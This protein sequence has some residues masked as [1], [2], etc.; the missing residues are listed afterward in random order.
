[1]KIICGISGGLGNQM[2]QYAYGRALSKRCGGELLL[3]L[4]WFDESYTTVTNRPLG[5]DLFNFDYKVASEEDILNIKGRGKRKKG[6]KKLLSFD[7]SNFIKENHYHFDESLLNVKKDSYF[8]GYFQSEKYFSDFE[9][10][11]KSDFAFKDE[12]ND[13]YKKL[14]Q[15][16]DNENSVGIHI[17]RG[18]YVNDKNTSIHHGV[19]S[20]EYYKEALKII[21]EKVKDPVF[22]FFSDDL[23]WVKDNLN[24]DGD[25][26]YVESSLAKDHEDMQLMTM[27]KH[28]IIANSSFSWWGAWLSVDKDKTVIAPLKWFND[29]SKNTKDLI[30]QGWTRI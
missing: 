30:P 19:C 20:V 2:F 6:L 1:M 22:Y 5:L 13:D 4:S 12:L 29:G 14:S 11:I 23:D 24:I 28:F 15:L 8:S 18:D 10:L 25:V 7:N 3:D 21:S 17:R 27:C 9:E 26:V 16:M